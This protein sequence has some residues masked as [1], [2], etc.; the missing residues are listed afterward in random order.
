MTRSQSSGQGT[1]VRG[2]LRSWLSGR[3][4]KVRDVWKST[5]RPGRCN[6]HRV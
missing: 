5:I 6:P 4:R 2:L 1:G 3:Q